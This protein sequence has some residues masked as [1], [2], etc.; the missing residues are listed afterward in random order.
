MKA[1]DYSRVAEAIRFIEANVEHQPGLADLA[2]HLGLSAHF[3]HRLFHKWAGITPKDFLQVLTLAKAK[4]LLAASGSVLDTSLA[5]G[6]S[7]SGRLHDLFLSLEAMTPGAYKAKASGIIIRWG[8]HATP[9]GEALFAATDRGLCG[10]SFVPDQNA[11]AVVD[12]LARRWPEAVLRE[13]TRFLTPVMREVVSRMRGGAAASLHLA[14][15]GSQFQVKVWEA[16]LSIPERH[17]TTY[18]SLAKLAGA[19]GAARAVGNA[20]AV[21]PI[22]YIIPC[23]RVIR[24]TGMIGDYRWGADRKM[25]MLA[26]EGAR[27]YA[28]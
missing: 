7:G 14:L 10:L 25:V 9:F 15:K 6:L 11:R 26:V 12:D 2:R 17:V 21:N 8:I 20:V 28:G 5:V 16:L 19:P 3:T 4:R 1:S 24:A 13:D 18:W 27:S 22:G 23:H